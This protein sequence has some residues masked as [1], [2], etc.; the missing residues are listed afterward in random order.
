MEINYKLK[1][2][3]KMLL[4]KLNEPAQKFYEKSAF[5]TVTYTADYIA[6][7]LENY[8]IGQYPIT[9]DVKFGNIV[10]NPLPEGITE[11]PEGHQPQTFDVLNRTTLR[12]FES[13][14]AN[15]GTDDNHLLDVVA[16]KF[17]KTLVSKQVFDK[18]IFTN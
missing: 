2:S 3:I 16:A 15:W 6:V 7:R 8:V 13:D 4:G 17:G 18:G 5:E 14:V 1:N 9:V 10:D 12:L 11:Y